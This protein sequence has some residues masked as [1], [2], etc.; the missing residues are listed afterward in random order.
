MAITPNT[1]LRLLAWCLGL[2][3]LACGGSVDNG[4][5][6]NPSGLGAG[7]AGNGTGSKLLA[8]CTPGF[9]EA[10]ASSNKPCY[11]LVGDTCYSTQDQACGCICPRDQGPV[12]CVTGDAG[13]RVAGIAAMWVMCQAAP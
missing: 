13:Q 4:Q 7:D 2:G 12:L 11:Y 8:D 5:S 6:S 10:Q 9:P 3:P 1:Y